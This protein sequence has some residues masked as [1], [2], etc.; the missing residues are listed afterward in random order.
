MIN[1]VN[2]IMAKQI[3][4]L[5]YV[6]ITAKSIPIL[7]VIRLTSVRMARKYLGRVLEGRTFK[8]FFVFLIWEEGKSKYILI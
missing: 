3:R 8:T 5:I 7:R 4:N 6:Y 1:H 2:S